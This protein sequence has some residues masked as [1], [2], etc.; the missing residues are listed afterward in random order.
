[1]NRWTKVRSRRDEV[2]ESGQIWIEV[3][4]KERQQAGNKIY[5]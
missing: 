4:T 1:M 2:A 5:M 3:E